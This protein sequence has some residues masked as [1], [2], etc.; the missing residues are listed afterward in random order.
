MLAHP[1]PCILQPGNLLA[2]IQ[3]GQGLGEGAALRV[4]E[5]DLIAQPARRTHISMTKPLHHPALLLLKLSTSL[6]S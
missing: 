4:A 6:S 3:P 1:A 5:S 2:W